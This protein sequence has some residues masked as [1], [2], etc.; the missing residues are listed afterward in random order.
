VRSQSIFPG[1][2]TFISER[3]CVL[4]REANARELTWVK[5][6][7]SCNINAT[8]TGKL[9][10]DAHAMWSVEIPLWWDKCEEYDV[11]V[12]LDGTFTFASNGGSETLDLWGSGKYIA[13]PPAN[14]RDEPKEKTISPR[15]FKLKF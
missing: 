6:E 7:T 8:I 4:V 10:A 2:I 9:K 14:S 3:W 12:E 5:N 1:D 11:T 13:Q 15:Y